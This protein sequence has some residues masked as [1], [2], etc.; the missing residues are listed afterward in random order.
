M[1]EEEKEVFDRI[2]DRTQNGCKCGQCCDERV[3]INII[4][5]QQKEIERLNKIINSRYYHDLKC[6]EL[7]IEI[8]ENWKDKIRELKEKIKKERISNPYD[9][10]YILQELLEEK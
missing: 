2:K 4:D 1:S 10:I 7:E 8:D 3:L 9:F 6:R 5:K